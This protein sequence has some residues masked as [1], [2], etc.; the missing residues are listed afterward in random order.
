MLLEHSAYQTT[1]DGI[2]INGAVINEKASEL[3]L[4]IIPLKNVYLVVR[5]GSKPDEKGIYK[6]CMYSSL[7]IFSILTFLKAYKMGKEEK[8]RG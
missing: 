8:E 6:E 7:S 5:L 2:E 1:K 4:E 3:G